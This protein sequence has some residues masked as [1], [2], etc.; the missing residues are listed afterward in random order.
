MSAPSLRQQ[1]KQQIEKS[2]SGN[3]LFMQ[4]VDEIIAAAKKFETGA[5][6]LAVGLAAPQFELPDAAGK[7]V[8]LAELLAKGP[9][10]VTFYRGSWCPYCSLQLKALQEVLPEIHMLGGSLVAISPQVPDSSLNSSE[11]AAMDFTV[12]SDQDARTAKEYGVSWEVPER[13]LQHMRDDRKLDLESINNGNANI[14]PIP[15]T[16]VLNP[17]GVVTWRF[18]DVDYRTRAEPSDIISELRK[19]SAM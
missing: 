14:L 8:S 19:I 3:P 9:V 2:R 11:K 5:D 4:S 10:V 17:Q 15:A 13:I 12:L 18:V 1:T 6:A 7:V 16:F